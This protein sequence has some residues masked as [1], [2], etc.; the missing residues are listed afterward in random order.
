MVINST[1]L[2]TTHHFLQQH[3]FYPLFLASCIAGMMLIGRVIFG[4]SLAYAH[5]VWNLFLAWV[6]YICSLYISWRSQRTQRQWRLVVPA[7]MWLSFLPNAPYLV[8]EYIHLLEIP[9]FALWYD[10]VMLTTFAWVGCVLAVASLRMM[11]EVAQ[12]MFGL[13]R[14]WLLV[15]SVI[16]LSGLGVYLGRFLRWNSW[17]LLLNPHHVVGDVA[18]RLA[19]PLAYPGAWGVTLMFSALLL[20]C[21]LCFT[22]L[23]PRRPFPKERFERA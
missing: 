18:L 5:M 6:P 7:L 3:A 20:V 8:T 2:R 17:D 15:L 14:G 13:V 21:Y 9:S 12:S 10:I 22:A 4:Q 1:L 19:D 11:H 23:H 16:A